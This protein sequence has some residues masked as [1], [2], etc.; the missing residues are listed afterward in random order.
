MSKLFS[1]KSTLM[2]TSQT[3]TPRPE[4]DDVSDARRRN[5]AAIKG[6]DTRPEMLVRR[7]VHG[8]GYRYRLHVNGL[9]GR[10]DIVLPS[11]KKIIEV[12]GCFWHRHSGCPR[13]AIPAARRDFWIDKFQSTI[14]RDIQNLAALKASGWTVKVIWE[15]ETKDTHLK[16]RLRHFLEQTAPKQ[17]FRQR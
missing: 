13:S 10:P 8:M 12:R 4:F 7:I 17:G 16:D 1:H 15:C 5:M 2:Q 11:R 9:P 14:A 6:K 3:K